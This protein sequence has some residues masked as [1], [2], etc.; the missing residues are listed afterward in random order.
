MQKYKNNSLPRKRCFAKSRDFLGNAKNYRLVRKCIY[1][2][3]CM[4]ITLMTRL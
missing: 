4:A 3:F 2:L 1:K